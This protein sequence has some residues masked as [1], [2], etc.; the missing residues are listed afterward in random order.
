[1]FRSLTA[2]AVL[3]VL[4]LLAVDLP[5]VAAPPG[6]VRTDVGGKHLYLV[7]MREAPVA[8]YRGEVRGLAATKP[9]RGHRVNKSDPNV[10]RYVDYLRTKQDA[11]ARSVGNFRKIY[12]YTFALNG[13][14]AELSDEQ[15]SKLRSNP[16]VLF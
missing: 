1:M 9:A 5:A 16:A 10:A 8:N 11:V 2:S 6:A 13:F 3:T 4:T 7:Q 12:S 15:A 14:A